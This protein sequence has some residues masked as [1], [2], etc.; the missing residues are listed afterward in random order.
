MRKTFATALV[1]AS[2]TIAAAGASAESVG[3]SRGPRTYVCDYA[4][5]PFDLFCA[6]WKALNCAKGV[7]EGAS[8]QQPLVKGKLD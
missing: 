2:L 4:C 8:P 6:I 7:P 5:P 1:S 3:V